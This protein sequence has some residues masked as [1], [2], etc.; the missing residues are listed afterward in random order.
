MVGPPVRDKQGNGYECRGEQL[1]VIGIK[2]ELDD[3]SDDYIIDNGTYYDAAKPQCEIAE[4]LAE[5]HLADNNGGETY[6]YGAA[7]HING[8]A[9]EILSIERSA[10]TDKT[11]GDDKSD[12]L[13]RVCIDTLSAAHIAVCSGCAD[14]AAQFG[15]E[16]PVKGGN[17][18]Y[19]E[20]QRYYAGY[21]LM[22]DTDQK[23]EFI[24]TY[25]QHGFT[26][27]TQIDGL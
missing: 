2:T 5:Q 24:H 22:A 7:A 14:R 27:D 26:H 16:E 19:N 20:N 10:E 12:D 4:E 3:Q 6:D 9:A 23:V 21:L 18:S 25:R 15:A 8:H 13:H 1:K 17:Y 11:I